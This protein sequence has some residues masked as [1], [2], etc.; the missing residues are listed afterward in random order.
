[1]DPRGVGNLSGGC[2]CPEPRTGQSDLRRQETEA[3]NCRASFSC[4]PGRKELPRVKADPSSLRELISWG[5]RATEKPCM[6]PRVTEAG[7]VFQVLFSVL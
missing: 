7:A 4:H 6:Q 2:R 3:R 5:R 1:M